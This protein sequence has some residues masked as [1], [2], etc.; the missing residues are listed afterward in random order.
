MKSPKGFFDPLQAQVL[1]WTLVSLVV[2]IAAALTASLI[3]VIVHNQDSL[4]DDAA[5]HVTAIL[6]VVGAAIAAL[7]LVV[8]FR[9]DGNAMDIEALTIRFRGGAGAL[10][11]WILAFLAMVA[12]LRILWPMVS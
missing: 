2:M 6:C 10:L 5:H 8:F 9:R 11:L 4:R 12:G 7:L 1:K 3:Y